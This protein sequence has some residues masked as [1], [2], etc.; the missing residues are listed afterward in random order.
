MGTYQTRTQ[1]RKAER[2]KD[3]IVGAKSKYTK[4]QRNAVKGLA[5][6]IGI[7]PEDLMDLWTAMAEND[8]LK[9]ETVDEQNEIK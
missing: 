6:D 2:K 4:A 7:T 5:K 1:R 9:N 3:K 8:A